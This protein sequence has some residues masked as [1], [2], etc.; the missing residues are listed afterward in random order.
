MNASIRSYELPL[1][2]LREDNPRDFLAAL[3]L[4]RLV[5]YKWPESF[6]KLSWSE[7]KGLPTLS[8][9]STLPDD[10]GKD[11]WRLLLE[12]KVSECN[13]FGHGKIEM[14]APEAFRLLLSSESKRSPIH[15]RFY[16]A[17]SAQIPHDQMG[18]RSEFII[19]SASRSVLNGINS[20]LGLKLTVIDVA[21]D[22]AGTGSRYEVANTSRWN[23]AEFQ[24]AAYMAPDPE[25]TNLRDHRSLNV[26]A[27][28][29]LTFYPAVDTSRGRRTTGMSRA[30]GGLCFSWPTWACPLTAEELAS[31]LH[32]PSIHSGMADAA[33]LKGIGVFQVWRSRKFKQNG[34]NLYF[35]KAKP[36]F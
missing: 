24:S 11:L 2:G 35:S 33:E 7:E 10:W 30:G 23:P 6:P 20:L 5:A 14:I 12:W 36:S 22:F 17:L 15:A 16:P 26:F 19:E 21:G 29:G 25:K 9:A 31:L 13:P 28:L 27:L 3:G 32:H 4:L 34:E 8:L 18:R 1:P